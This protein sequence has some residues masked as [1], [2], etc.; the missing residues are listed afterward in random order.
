MSVQ[1]CC[2]LSIICLIVVAIS[3]GYKS[4][5]HYRL[6][7]P[8]RK[9]IRLLKANNSDEDSNSSSSEQDDKSRAKLGNWFTGKNH[10]E[11]MERKSNMVF[12]PSVYLDNLASSPSHSTISRSQASVAS[13][14]SVGSEKN[15]NMFEVNTGADVGY[16]NEGSESSLSSVKTDPSKTYDADSIDLHLEQASKKKQF[17][18]AHRNKSSYNLSAAKFSKGEQNLS[19]VGLA[20]A[21]DKFR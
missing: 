15:V 21:Q 10:I 11:T 2:G 7:E 12:P 19:Q 3:I 9:H 13:S 18:K 6:E 17:M 20:D 8:N 4:E 16:S 1:V 5:T 14:P